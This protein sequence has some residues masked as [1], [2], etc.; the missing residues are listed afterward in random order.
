MTHEDFAARAIAAVQAVTRTRDITLTDDL[1]P[2]LL[3][4]LSV[5]RLA[6]T[7]KHDGLDVS[8]NDLFRCNTV[9]ELAAAL[10]RSAVDAPSAAAPTDGPHVPDAEVLADVWLAPGPP[11]AAPAVSRPQTVL[12]T[13]AT[14]FVGRHVLVAL[15]RALPDVRV[16]CLVRAANDEAA[17]ARVSEAVRRVGGIPM[18]RVSAFR[19]DLSEADLG[20]GA[21]ARLRA[22]AGVD[23]IVHVGAQVNRVLDYGRLRAVNVTATRELLALAAHAGI[24]TLHHVSTVSAGGQ[25]GYG[26][27]KRA[28]E[29]LVSAAAERGLNASVYRLERVSGSQADGVWQDDDLYVRMLRGSI[30]AGAVP[31]LGPAG[32]EVWT[33]VDEVAAA[34]AGLVMTAGVPARTGVMTLTG[35][36]VPYAKVLT[37]VLAA[38]PTMQVL[39]RAAWVERIMLDDDN[40][41]QVVAAQWSPGEGAPAGST[42]G[43]L[44][45]VVEHPVCVSGALTD[46]VLARYVSAL[47]NA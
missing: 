25:S 8:L 6:R 35:A 14:G 31:D 26:R 46:E 36:V 15:L 5:L 10:A 47:G 2:L 30:N 39:S 42:N 1:S 23:T 11:F 38:Y 43:A 24:G 41:A 18:H 17:L 37:A 45:E 20:L 21:E 28:S 32:D 33:P 13:G 3:S 16:H 22:C 29:L 44:P 19:A 27:S 4:S 9:G 12:M 34:L 40:V 7:L